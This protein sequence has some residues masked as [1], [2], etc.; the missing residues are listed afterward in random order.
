MGIIDDYDFK[1]KLPFIM[2]TDAIL[3][4]S[5]TIIHFVFFFFVKESDFSNAFDAFNSSPLFDFSVGSSCGAKSH[6][7]FHVW[8]GRKETNHHHRNLRARSKT[9]I[10]GKTDIAIINGNYFC[11]RD[12]SYK[13]LLYNGQIIKKEEK[14]EGEYSKD[15]GKIDTLNQHLCIKDTE[16]C[17][18]YDVGIGEKIDSSDYD[19]NSDANI[20]YNNENYNKADKKIIGKLILNDGQ[21]CYKLSEKLWRKFD[22]KEAGK[23]HLKCEVEIFG[24]YTDDRYDEKGNIRYRKIYEDNLSKTNQDLVFDDIKD[25]SV[26]LY[27][28]EFLGIDKACDEK[29]NISKD[30]YKILKKSQKIEGI[31]LLVES[32]ILFCFLVP[33]II[34][35]SIVYFLV[36]KFDILRII[37]F[38]YLIVGLILIF[39]CIICHG[40]FLGRIIANNISYNCSD[41]I[42]NEVLRKENENTK[43][44]IIYTAINLG[45][46][47]FIFL[48][49]VCAIILFFLMEKYNLFKTNHS[50]NTIR[51]DISEKNNNSDQN[52]FKSGAISDFPVREVIVNNE[53][54]KEA[55]PFSNQINNNNPNQIYDLGVPPTLE[56]GISSNTKI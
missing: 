32:I 36:K 40:V 45:L 24:K 28:R 26:T 2:V 52:K 3:V 27:S 22:S 51:N 53:T 34:V 11:Y 43:K 49:N 21:P 16:K 13:K 47:I 31:I 41:A 50:D 19:Y 46:N 35:A 6:I 9:I 23:E 14:C 29:N 7:T 5:I 55:Q 10:V 8:E 20:Y 1:E 4:I 56:Q 33:Y 54:P 39:A 38:F 42:T 37:A 48:F 44:S 30:D 18:L 25:E 15:C 17:P 12:I